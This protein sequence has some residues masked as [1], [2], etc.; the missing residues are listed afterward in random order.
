MAR[1]DTLRSEIA[2][3]QSKKAGMYAD[4]AKHECTASNARDA[5]RKKA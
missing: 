4:V 2:R 5:A 3:L 1:S